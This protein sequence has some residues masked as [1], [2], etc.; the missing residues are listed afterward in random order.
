MHVSA[1][2]LKP[3]LSYTVP[4]FFGPSAK[5]L[6]NHYSHNINMT[7]SKRSIVIAGVYN[8]FSTGMKSTCSNNVNKKN[9]IRI[10][11]FDI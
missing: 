4:A 3:A 9:R 7:L 5:C 6:N 8:C 1:L 10:G 11:L 2:T